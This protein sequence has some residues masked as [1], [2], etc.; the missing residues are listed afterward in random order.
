MELIGREREAAELRRCHA[1]A[2]PHFVAV[3]GRRRVGKTFL[4]RQVLGDALTFTVT[5]IAK[6]P[7]RVQLENFAR[8]LRQHFGESPQVFS[9]WFDAFESL[10]TCLKRLPEATRKTIFLDEMPWMD[11][12]KSGFVSALEWF[13]NGWC[14]A[15]PD[16]LLIVCG[17]ATAWIT[18]RLFR[19][20]AGLHNR[21]T[22]RIEV[23]PFTLAE[24]AAYTE[25]RGLVMTE[26]ELLEA[27][28]V[29]GGIPY[30]LSLL[31][32]QWSLAQNIGRLCFTARGQ[33]HGEFDNLY[34]SLFARPDS[35]I[36]IV[37]ALSRKRCGMTR[38]E[39][40]RATRLSPSGTLTRT[41]KELAESC[42]IRAYRPYG[43]KSRGTVYQLIDFFTLFHF[44]FMTDAPDDE[45][46]WVKYSLGGGHAAWSGLAF[47]Q[48][49][50]AHTRQILAA[51]GIGAVISHLT[52]WRSETVQPGAQ[53]DLVIDRADQVVNLCEM[54]YAPG[55]YVVTKT[56]HD[57]LL[58]KRAAFIAETGV[59]RAVHL[60]LVTTF[61]VTRNKY[62]GDVQS[63][64]TSRDL[65]WS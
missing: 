6:A 55:P 45:D 37:T 33:L 32:P 50:L 14:S 54:K 52:A 13:W 61:G 21:V 1:A 10:A 31:E 29:F 44:T 43:R 20:T 12:H 49:C 41:L 19:N 3:Y 30:Y 17:S 22:R 65:F 62:S 26:R 40:A 63:F 58:N 64:V 15:R 42:F 38:D 5:G 18:K 59:T 36:A 53:V 2:E 56:V 47:E 28:M 57:D 9:S 51:L 4:V 39:I 27:H 34:A 24:C 48:V 11:T 23:A 16:I 60:T 46:Y 25:A 7:M 35:H 8:S